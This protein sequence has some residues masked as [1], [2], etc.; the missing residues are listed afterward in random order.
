MHPPICLYLVSAAVLGAC[1][2]EAAQ[3]APEPTP[4]PPPKPSLPPVAIASPTLEARLGLD[5]PRAPALADIQGS[6]RVAVL[7]SPESGPD[8]LTVR[9]FTADRRGLTRDGEV[10]LAP[11]DGPTYLAWQDARS[12]V[13]LMASG[14]LV[15]VEEGRA[16]P[17]PRPPERLFAATYHGQDAVRTHRDDG[18]IATASGAVWIRHCAWAI[19]GDHDP[20]VAPVY[21]RVG[22]SPIASTEPPTPR[23]ATTPWPNLD[24][25]AMGIAPGADGRGT[26][27]CRGPMGEKGTYPH[28][29]PAR[30]EEGVQDVHWVS[31]T[32]PI[33]VADLAFAGMDD[34]VT[35]ARLVAGCTLLGEDTHGAIT[36][37][38]R[39]FWA[40]ERAPFGDSDTLVL[41]HGRIVGHVPGA[42][43][44]I[45]A[46]PST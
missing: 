39:P 43:A 18:L 10:A 12:L 34:V 9:I 6:A 40:L 42:R 25:W 26:L 16:S 46:P 38:P 8:H 11:G 28:R 37:G 14:Q 32:P 19:A 21:V 5:G 2:T 29:D 31:E 7:T 30:G 24:T 22:P 15:R 27:E 41:Y 1:G 36:E 45:F 20:C 33:A 3:S 17:L 13:V 35:H 23:P 4:E 44:I